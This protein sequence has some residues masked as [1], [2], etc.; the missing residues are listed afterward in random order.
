M[1]NHPALT[2]NLVSVGEI[3]PHSHYGL[4]A[5]EWRAKVRYD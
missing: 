4:N 1:T 2:V 5:K 3:K